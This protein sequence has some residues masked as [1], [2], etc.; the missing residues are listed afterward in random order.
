MLE[1]DPNKRISAEK[2]IVHP[3]IKKKVHET[4]DLK[5]TVA[6]LNNLK[7]F[8]VSCTEHRRQD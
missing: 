1:Y 7:N 5:S 8:R 3:W 4:V 2:A 6:A